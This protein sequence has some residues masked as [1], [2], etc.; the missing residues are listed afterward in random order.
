MPLTPHPGFRGSGPTMEGYPGALTQKVKIFLPP[1]CTEIFVH[2]WQIFVLQVTLFGRFGGGAKKFGHP[3]RAT[4]QKAGESPTHSL[5][6]RR[7]P[8]PPHLPSHWSDP[9]PTTSPSHF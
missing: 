1:L 3:D 2:F 8:D 5:L 9:P 6:D 7:G 4:V